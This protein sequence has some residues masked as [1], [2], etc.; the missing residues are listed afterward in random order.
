[1]KRFVSTL[2][3]VAIVVP[4]T[5][6]C[7]GGGL[8]PT[9]PTTT[10]G[11]LAI[12]MST[13][14]AVEP[15]PRA[16]VGPAAS[17]PADVIFHNGTVLTMEVEYPEVQAI[18]IRGDNVIAV[19][20]D[21]GVLSLA[22]SKTQLVDLA[23][24]TLLPGFVA[25]HTHILRFPDRAGKTLD[26]AME[27]ALGYGYT[28]VTEKAADEPFIEQLMEAEREGRLRLRVN[29]FAEYNGGMLDDEGHQFFMNVWFPEH[30]PIVDHDRR[31][32][33]PGIK[34]F[35]DGAFRAER[36]CW[37][38]T[39][40]FPEALLAEPWFQE[41]D[42]GPQGELYLSQDELN[43]AVA[44]A[45]AAGFS[46]AF[47]AM[48]DRAIDA[49]LNAIEYALNGESNEQ[50][51]HQIQ[52]N[53][54]VRP[55]QLQRYA[56]LNAAVEVG[57]YF[58]T[59][60]QDFYAVFG[61][62]RSEWVANRYALPGLGIHA[63][64]GGGDFGWRSD[65]ADPSGLD[66]LIVL[67]GMVTHQ[68]LREDGS[69]CEPAPWIA[70]HQISVERALQMLTIEPAWAVSQEEVIGSLRP[71]KFADV[72]ILSDNP[73]AVEP[74]TIEDLRVLMTMVGG[75]VEYC[76]PAHESLCPT[77][78][79]AQQS[80]A[81]TLAPTP[82]NTLV[83]PAATPTTELRE[84]VEISLMAEGHRVPS[85]TPIVLRFGWVT[86]THEQV[87]DFLD[88]VE[89]VVSVDGE[90][91]DDTGKYWGEIEELGD[92]DQDGDTDY[93]A[94]WLYPVGVLTL[95]T[96]RVESEMRLQ[97][98]VVDGF[99]SDGNGVPDEFSGTTGFSLQIV[100]GE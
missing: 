95:G 51:R 73:L 88:S 92:R 75:R 26:E 33:I 13:P 66:P 44:A 37:A 34:I 5:T 27:V 32:R 70:R 85:N 99:D 12:P 53:S 59:C 69:V 40:P 52:H 17:E 30:G 31:L 55:D 63:Y 64:T 1:M 49:A 87:A 50:Y 22:G 14:E 15:T 19:G 10:A 91:V 100:V 89:L 28:T 36:G 47:H 65:P 80:T 58:N 38:V 42:C 11:F 2:L 20:S 60:E 96:H 16:T 79:A 48:G 68:Q 61:P 94:L 4:L 76:A 7:G 45:Q 90:L 46:V 71:G 39:E 83:P 74:D 18:A 62:E 78:I 72:V 25:G 97:R 98:P 29:V 86:D 82:T 81:T 9:S 8:Q 35:V 23:G 6:A 84:P 77:T 43:E 21:E 93:Q 3:L 41:L 24:R 57:G 56:T 54:L 67:Y